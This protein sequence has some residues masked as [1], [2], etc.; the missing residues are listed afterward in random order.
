MRGA[1]TEG[2]GRALDAGDGGEFLRDALYS[3]A[4]ILVALG[5]GCR[6]MNATNVSGCLKRAPVLRLP[7][8]LRLEAEFTR[9]EFGFGGAG[10]ARNRNVVV[11]EQGDDEVFPIGA[12]G[13]P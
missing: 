10:V 4:R 8:M 11:V 2:E 13:Q 9:R 7:A 1:V 12:L 5:A 6:F 3:A